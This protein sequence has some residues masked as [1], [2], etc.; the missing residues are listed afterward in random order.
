MSFSNFSAYFTSL[1]KALD[2]AQITTADGQKINWDSFQERI[3]AIIMDVVRGGHKIVFVGNGGSAGIASHMAIDY[4]KNGGIRAIACNDAS[5]LTCLSNDYAYEDVFAKQIEYY[6]DPGDMLIAISSSGGSQNILNTVAA[7]RRK[8]MAVLTLSGFKSANPL[9][10][11]GDFN[12]YLDAGEYGYVEVGHLACCH[13][14]L[15]L[16]TPQVE[17]YHK[18][19]KKAA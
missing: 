2:E 1:H 3:G 5:A 12:I 14:I 9:R 13:A 10:E 17:A 6:A 8:G 16:T 19:Q 7:A 11:Q 15:D 18:Q 4:T